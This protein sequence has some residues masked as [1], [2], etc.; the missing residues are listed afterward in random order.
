MPAQGQTVGTG[1]KDPYFLDFLGLRHGH[2]EADLE[3]AILR[4]LE[5]FILELGRGFAFVERPK[6]KD[7]SHAMGGQDRVLPVMDIDST[8]QSLDNHAT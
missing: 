3:A 7:N 8:W 1:F 6:R 4:Q 5:A 2:E